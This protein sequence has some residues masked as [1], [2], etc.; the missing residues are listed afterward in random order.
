MIWSAEKQRR[1]N[2]DWFALVPHPVAKAQT[3]W[4]RL[5]TV[6]AMREAGLKIDDIASRF[7]CHYKN[8]RVLVYKASRSVDDPPINKYLK[9]AALPSVADGDYP[10]QSS[11]KR[12]AVAMTACLSGEM[13][14]PSSEI[15]Y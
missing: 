4:E 5:R 6:K 2:V 12:A 14:K 11:R 1:S 13:T 15:W 3:A 8:A 9:A 10:N 7:G